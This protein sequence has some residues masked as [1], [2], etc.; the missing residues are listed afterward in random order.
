MAKLVRDK[1]PSIVKKRGMTIRTHI[2]KDAEYWR[3]LKEKLLEETEELSSN[4]SADELVDILEVVYAMSKFRK[5]STANLEK[6]RKEK[7]A[8]IGAFGG[9]I[10]SD[11]FRVSKGANYTIA[12]AND[13]KLVMKARDVY[14]TKRE[15]GRV[16]IIGGSENFHGAPVLASNATYSVLAAL[17]VGI[18][19]ATTFVPRSVLAQNRSLSPNVIVRPLNLNNLNTK[20]FQML[21][22]AI[23]NSECVVMGNGL[24]RKTDSLKS[25]SK[26]ISYALRKSKNVV[27]DA[28]AIYSVKVNRIR[29]NK[30]FLVTPNEK[31]FSLFWKESL[32]PKNL[33][34]RINA[35]V[36]VSNQLNCTIL[37]K[38]HDTI[39]TDGTRT[40][41]ISS[42]SSALGTMGTGDVLSGIIGGFAANNND[43]FKA[44]V[45]GAYLHSRIGDLLHSEKGNH[46]LAS[47][48]IDYIPKILRKLDRNY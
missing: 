13:L 28:D 42:K 29:L 10:I 21:A 11:Y 3:Y 8:K 36:S 22:K 48:V 30:N 38:G 44:A 45:A 9:R 12:T 47:D 17:R 20:D 23:D 15:N 34:A 5:M 7:E 1:I 6:L 41:I 16:T 26:L 31:E 32:D 18:G 35:A 4:P 19:Y 39:V 40:K 43:L 46:I 25:V 33:E 2:A 27:I 24:G 14:S 37:L